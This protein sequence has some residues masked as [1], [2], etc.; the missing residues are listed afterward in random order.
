MIGYIVRD[1]SDCIKAGLPFT[2]HTDAPCSNVGTLQLIQT[3]VTR[4]C[5]VDDSVVGPEQAVSLTEALKAVTVNAA[6]QIGMDDRLG[7]LERGKEA[8]LTILEADPYKVDPGAITNIKV[9]ETW[10]AGEKM[11]G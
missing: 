1:G 8:D 7:S 9:S 5:V 10:V 3:A 2:L 4:R 11:H 6:G